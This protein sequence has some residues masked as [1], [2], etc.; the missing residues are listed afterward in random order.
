MAEDVK[1]IIDEHDLQNVTLIGHSMGAKIAL[2]VALQCPESVGNVIAIDNIP[3]HLPLSDDFH[4]YIEAL[5]RVE[6]AKVTTHAQADFIVREYEKSSII[7]FF[8]LTNLVSS[9]ESSYLRFRIPLDVL[10]TALGPL[11][12]FPF[13]AEEGINFNKPVLFIRATQSHYIPHSA[14]PQ[15]RLFFPNASLVEMD[16]GHW[17]I[18]EKPE[19]FAQ[20]KIDITH[21]RAYI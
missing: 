6:Q 20:C 15:I 9:P 1:G 14:L 8:L 5:K 18:Q 16:C 11:E 4:Q 19:Q 17:V 12:D 3:I 10:S 21:L 2:T 7:R 13:A